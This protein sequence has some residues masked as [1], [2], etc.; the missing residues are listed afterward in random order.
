MLIF[1]Y[2]MTLPCI[3]THIEVSMKAR[4]IS[5]INFKGGCTKT[6]SAVGLGSALAM[7]GLRVLIVDCD[8]QSHIAVHVGIEEDDVELSI[9]DVLIN[10]KMDVT[11]IVWKT[12]SENLFVVPSGRNLLDVREVLS[13]RP[14]R[15]ALLSRSLGP[16]IGKFDYIIIDTPPDEGLLSVNAMYACEYFIVPT[17]LD[18]F[19]LRGMNPLFDAIGAMQDAYDT[20]KLELLGI[21]I[22]RYDQRLKT[23]NRRNLDELKDVFSGKIFKTYIRSDEQ[24]RMAQASGQTIFERGINTKGAQDFSRL[25]DEVMERTA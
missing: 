16:A 2:Y 8:P 6:T 12:S 10:R 13:N 20:R 4:I 15:D 23:E 14:R 24:I 7:R 22:N 3:I 5:F 25:A 1:M 9:R 19:S 17:P 11:D 18:S 21:L